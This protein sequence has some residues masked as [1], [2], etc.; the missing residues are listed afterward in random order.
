MRLSCRL[1]P[2]NDRLR[3]ER[4]E[5]REMGMRGSDAASGALFFYADMEAAAARQ[6]GSSSRAKSLQPL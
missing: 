4:D 2:G 3:M 5:Q 6:R 1:Q